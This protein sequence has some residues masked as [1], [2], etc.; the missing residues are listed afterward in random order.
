MHQL[1]IVTPGDGSLAVAGKPVAFAVRTD[2]PQLAA[3]VRWSV[4]TQPGEPGAHGIGPA[5]T[6]TFGATGVEQ[7][8]AHLDD[9]GL[10]CDVVVYVFKTR[11]GGSNL[12]DVLRSEPPPVARSVASLRR[13][14]ASSLAPRRA[15]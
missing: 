10:T 15:S 2:P 12:A 1:E 6:Y 4:A 8:V 5:F 14:G 9:A 11:T 7:V 3:R 13:W